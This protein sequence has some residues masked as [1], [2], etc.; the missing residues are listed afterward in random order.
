[1][2]FRCVVGGSRA[3]R[4]ARATLLAA[5]GGRPVS[6][7]PSVERWPFVRDVVSGARRHSATLLA[8]LQ[9]AFPAGQRQGTRLVLTQSTYQLQRWLDWLDAHPDSVVVAHASRTL[10]TV[11]PEVGLRRG[12]WSRIEITWLEGDEE[13]ATWTSPVAALS[14]AFASG[15]PDERLQAVVAARGTSAGDPALALAEASV[16]MERDDLQA[17]QRAL[18]EAA[19]TAPEWEAVWFEYG[20][21]WLRGDDLERAAAMF[22]RASELMPSFA[23]ALSNLGAALGEIDRPQEA[24]A[25]L[26]QV[27]AHDPG[28]YSA[29]NNLSV[30]CREQG[31]LDDA[32]AASREVI[33]LA[34]AFVF[35]HYNLAHTLFL[36]GEF[37]AARDAYEQGQAR[38]PQRNPVQAA[39]LAVVRA[40]AGDAA[41][42]TQDLA[43]IAAVVPAELRARILDEA[44]AT[45]SALTEANVNEEVPVL[46]GVV[47]ELL[48]E[49]AGRGPGEGRPGS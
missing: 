27:L 23:N 42:A 43:A 32:L 46:L 36:M 20:K 15:S 39:R 34:P 35:G 6:E 28:H 17:A 7:G 10:A 19:S 5:D 38:D 14:R 1:M 31:Q 22:A 49:K 44:E 21:L 24:M 9:L 13:G 33:R 11:A 40:A 8:D 29:L 12:P 30:I 47:R 26:R 3:A 2:S 45:L 4:V 41:G 16:H 25:A 18:D 37:A 48:N